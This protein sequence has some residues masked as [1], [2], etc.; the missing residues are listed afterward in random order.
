MT[1]NVEII[2][3][4]TNENGMETFQYILKRFASEHEINGISTTVINPT[5]FQERIVATILY[6]D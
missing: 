6:S 1:K 3:G 2:L 4:K 5:T